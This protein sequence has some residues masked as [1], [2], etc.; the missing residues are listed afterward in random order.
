MWLRQQT[1]LK[2]RKKGITV[3]VGTELTN[4]PFSQT[5]PSSHT[6]CVQTLCPWMADGKRNCE[7][8][9]A[10]MTGR[11]ECVQHLNPH[12]KPLANM[13]THSSPNNGSQI[14]N[15]TETRVCVQGL[16]CALSE[17]N[18]ANQKGED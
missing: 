15:T 7:G 3:Q 10:V 11:M 6:R 14:G 1:H 8:Y 4:P 2:I 16:V 18:C 9:L 5:V 12:S 13:F 17:L